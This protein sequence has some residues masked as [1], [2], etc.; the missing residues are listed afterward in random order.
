MRVISKLAQIDFQFGKVCREGDLLV[1]DSDPN[2]KM[3]SRVY[4]SPQDVLEF[5][6]RFFLSPTA[7]LFVV[8][9]PYFLVRW[10]R[11][12]KAGSRKGLRKTKEW[13]TV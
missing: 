7:I 1:I 6:K 13:P 4:V 9:F 3:P 8:A 5:L 12:G 2:A 10:N 11:S